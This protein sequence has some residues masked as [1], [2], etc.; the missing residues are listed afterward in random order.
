MSNG[1]SRSE[2]SSFIDFLGDKGLM[3]AASATSRKSAVSTL[4]GILS[5]EEAEDVTKLDL[6]E[7]TSRFF[8]MKGKDF[9]PSSVAVY[10]S[11]VE[12]AIRDFIAYKQ[13]PLGF[14]PKVSP[15][16]GPRD[17]LTRSDK[18]PQTENT[19][20]VPQT[21]LPPTFQSVDNIFPI[22]IRPNLIVRI[23]GIPSDLT[24]AEARRISNVILALSVVE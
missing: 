2:L 6:N 1:M 15:T 18:Q 22:P 12:G 14:K 3:N 11:R 24:V 19:K 16:R 4:L 10:K 17:A 23:A 13:N 5:D 7:V 21:P 8:N 9:K 20:E